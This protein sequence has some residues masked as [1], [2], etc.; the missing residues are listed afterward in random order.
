MSVKIEELGKS[1]VKLTIEVSA[2]RFEEGINDAYKKNRGSIAIQGFRKGKA[3]R[4]LIEKAYGAS[5]FYEDAA[6]FCIP[7]AYDAAVE[8]AGLEVVSR[9]SIDVE[10]IE[11]GKPFI[12]TAEV[13]VKPEAV[14]GAYKGLEGS[15][16]IDV[17]SDE[18]VDAEITKVREQNSRLVDVTDRPVQDADQVNINFAGYVDGE[19]FEGGTSDNYELTIGSH[20]FIDTFEDQIIG[21][22]IDD[23]FEVNVTFPE[24]YHSADLAG[25]PAV[26]KVKVNSIKFKELPELDDELA[27]DVSEFDTFEEYK[28]DLRAKLAKSKEDSAMNKLK[29][30]LL[31]KA[32]E[33]ATIELP[34][35]MVDLEAENMVYDMSYRFQQQG[36]SME[37]YFQYTG[38]NMETLKDS[39]KSEAERKIKARLV[40]EAIAKS[41]NMEATDA[42]VEAEV[43]KMAEMYGVDVEKIKETIG[44]EEKE[45]IK[46]DLLNQKAFDFIVENA[47][48]A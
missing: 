33:N 39:M 40:L 7:D 45:S 36:L 48:L 27:Q 21:K 24:E 20:S 5:I 12:F 18:E 1:M 15:K 46:Q 31:D 41:E 44:D 30:E 28:A 32:V 38:Q 4:K 13:A 6:N 25:K 8:E 16:V 3:P 43:S 19:A 2:E 42:D 29:D 26:F 23:E 47:K 17:V 37:Q 14:L 11:A 9:P 22:N 35:P 10:Q 34:A